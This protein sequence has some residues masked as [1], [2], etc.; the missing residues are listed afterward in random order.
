[1]SDCVGVY[2]EEKNVLEVLRDRSK[3]GVF[4]EHNGTTKI[5]GKKN[6]GKKET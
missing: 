2:G 6:K 3:Y 1:M 5:G 4:F